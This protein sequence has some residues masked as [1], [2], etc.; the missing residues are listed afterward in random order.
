MPRGVDQ[1]GRGFEPG[2]FGRRELHRADR[3]RAAE[4]KEAGKTV[5]PI[6]DENAF[7]NAA[8]AAIARVLA[9]E[10]EAREAVERA[11]LE[12]NR[13]AESARLADRA[14][15]ERTERRIRAVIGAFERERSERLAAIEAE[16]AQLAQPRPL[17]PDELASLQRAVRTLA[18]ELV[19]APP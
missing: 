3:R 6:A 8:E 15:A 1:V 11:R 16:V 14:L 2:R 4:V 18:R 5:K 19:E 12:V 13:I 9:A 17:Q 10:R 7:N